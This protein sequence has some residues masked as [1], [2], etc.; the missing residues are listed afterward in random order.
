M[1]SFLSFTKL[2]AMK[3]LHSYDN[4]IILSNRLYDHF[5]IKPLLSVT[6]H[7]KN[8]RPAYFPRWKKFLSDDGPQRSFDLLKLTKIAGAGTYVDVT[9]AFQSHCMKVLTLPR[10]DLLCPLN[11][12]CRPQWKYAQ[13]NNRH[14]WSLKKNQ[15]TGVRSGLVTYLCFD[16]IRPFPKGEGKRKKL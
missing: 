13:M 3:L 4:L 5:P 11:W 6:V 12:R 8:L 10:N 9:H 2:N 1:P 15:N 7:C 16:I 14:P